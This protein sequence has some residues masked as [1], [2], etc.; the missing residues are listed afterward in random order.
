MNP[1]SFIHFSTENR[2]RNR[3]CITESLWLDEES[4][5]YKLQGREKGIDV[6][7]TELKDSLESADVVPV[8][9]FHAHP[10]KADCCIKKASLFMEQEMEEETPTRP[11]GENYKQELL[12]PPKI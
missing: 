10:V 3:Y 5:Q 7:E 8:T 9:K 2:D 1:F 11:A 6:K 12:S 4:P